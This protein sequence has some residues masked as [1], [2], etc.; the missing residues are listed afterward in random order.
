[1]KRFV[2]T[3]T[4]IFLIG[5]IAYSLIYYWSFIFSRKVEGVVSDVQRI[6]TPVAL[7]GGGTNPNTKE[8]FSFAVAIKEKSGEIV[9]ASSEDRQWAVVKPGLC[10]EARFYP[11]PPWDLGK[12]GTYANARLVKLHTCDTG[13]LLPTHP[14]VDAPLEGASPHDPQA[15][16]TPQEPS[17]NNA[18][19][20]KKEAPPQ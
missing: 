1:M 5:V 12:S 2:Y 9:T 19:P 10:A 14:P 7:I 13:Q 17:P 3:L 11:Y 6:Y 8:L 4:A 20:P 15:A 16:P 18:V